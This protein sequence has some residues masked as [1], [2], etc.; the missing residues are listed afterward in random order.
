MVLVRGLAGPLLIF[1]AAVALF[2]AAGRLP[3]VPVPGQLGPDFWPRLVLV[4]LMASCVL[5]LV[6]VARA[7][8]PAATGSPGPQVGLPKLVGGIA[9]VLGYPALAP[10]LGFPLTTALFL[11]AFMRLVGTRRVLPLTLTAA[12]GT[13][14]LLYV[15]VKVVYLPLPKGAGVF[16]DFT[17]FLYRLLRIF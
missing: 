5:K 9:L 10:L 15:F 1:L 3:V 12:L 11:A 13:V 7:K 6:E 8:G 17:I 4:A 16:E 2:V 14:S